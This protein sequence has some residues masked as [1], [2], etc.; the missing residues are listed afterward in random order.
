MS[1]NARLVF[2]AALVL[3]LGAGIA[4]AQAAK[5]AGKWEMSWE[6]RQGPVTAT[7]TFEQDGENLKGTLAGQQGEPAPLTGSVKGNNIAFAVKRTTP[8]G[9]FT[10]EYKGTVDGDAMK[11]TFMRGPQGQ[12]TEAPWTAK[13]SK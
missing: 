5:V 9:E 10:V 13:R 8:R 3:A 7:L 12:Q 6:G 2:V 4:L 1:R 11:G